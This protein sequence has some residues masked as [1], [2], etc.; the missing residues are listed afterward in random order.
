MAYLE[1]RQRGIGGGYTRVRKRVTRSW[2]FKTI[3][4]QQLAL[5]TMSQELVEK[6]EL[7][8]RILE[9]QVQARYRA[10]MEEN[11]SPGATAP[12]SMPLPAQDNL[13]LQA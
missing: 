3:K 4:A 2:L 8:A 10:A 12:E 9:E 5:E 13:V 7:H 11:S 6:R 1:T